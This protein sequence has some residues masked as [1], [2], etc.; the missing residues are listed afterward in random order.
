VLAIRPGQAA[1]YLASHVRQCWLLARGGSLN[2]KACRAIWSSHRGAA[3]LECWPRP[4][5]RRSTATRH[6]EAV[7]W[8]KRGSGEETTQPIH[9][10]FLFIG[11]TRNTDWLSQCGA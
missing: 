1:V 6:L 7:R 9:H 4:K 3:E 2:A 8:R 10:L 11:A 5:S